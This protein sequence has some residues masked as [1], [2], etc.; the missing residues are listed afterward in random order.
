MI[1][2][3]AFAAFTIAAI[4]SS[5]GATI[6]TVGPDGDY[7]S[8]QDAID[9]AIVAGG[10]DQIRVQVGTYPENLSISSSSIAGSLA[11]LGGWDSAFS[12]RSPH[13]ESTIIDGTQSGRPL[14]I[15]ISGGEVHFDSMT[16]SGGLVEDTLP[17]GGGFYAWLTGDAVIRM[18]NCRIVENTVASPS[19]AWG[20]GVS[21]RL[22]GTSELH[23]NRV[24]VLDNTAD[25]GSGGGGSGG[26]YIVA[27]DSSI[28]TI[29]SAVVDRNTVST[30]NL[31][32]LIQYGGLAVFGDDESMVSI[33]DMQVRANSLEGSANVWVSGAQLGG[34]QS[35]VVQRCRF[36]DNQAP[37]SDSVYQTFVADGR[38]TDSVVAGGN[39]N[40]ALLGGTETTITA[41][42]LTVA[43]APGTGIT[44]NLGTGS[45]VTL[46]NS[47]FFGN[48]DDLEILSTGAGTVDMGFNLSGVDPGFVDSAGR[49]YHLRIGSSAENAGTNT[50]PGGLGTLDCDGRPRLIDAIVDTGAFE[51]ISEIFIDGFESSTTYS[52][53]YVHP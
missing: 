8:L 52:W 24:F 28:V 46:F 36:I 25:C 22:E 16:F 15:E 41:T 9:V 37:S 20:G 34:G 42:N 53:S 38:I 6:L 7:A 3:T 4:T 10:E 29:S 39:A 44:L 32:A 14:T 45:F 23:L 48:A 49:D 50:P 5:L 13:A 30:S 26:L 40:G 19:Q 35:L 33:E 2:R 31:S 51:G 27:S 43:D 17:F 47:I 11:I 1:P 18:D 12:S 21:V